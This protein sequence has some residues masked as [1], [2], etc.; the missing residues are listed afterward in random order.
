M[1]DFIPK[2]E[3]VPKT[4]SKAMAAELPPSFMVRVTQRGFWNWL[5]YPGD[6]FVCPRHLYS[7][8]WMEIIPDQATIVTPE[9]L[10]Q[11]KKEL[12]DESSSD[13]G[14]LLR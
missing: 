4:I 14:R 12:T 13:E 11:R 2:G 3:A 5:R 1:A 10:Q 9:L 7:P 8:T 6:E